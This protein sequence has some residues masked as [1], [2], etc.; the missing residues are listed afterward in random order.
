M[1]CCRRWKIAIQNFSLGGQLDHSGIHFL[2][3]FFF[4]SFFSPFKKKKSSFLKGPSDY[5]YFWQSF[6]NVQGLRW[7]ICLVA[8]HWR[9][10]RLWEELLDSP[11]DSVVALQTVRDSERVISAASLHEL[12]YQLIQN[13]YLSSSSSAPCYKAR[14]DQWWGYSL[15]HQSALFQPWF[16]AT[17]LVWAS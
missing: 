15:V 8:W 12:L 9:E 10:T 17:I 14:E 13:S 3:S 11:S 5:Y 7:A 16:W 2:S 6:P 4:L 1:T